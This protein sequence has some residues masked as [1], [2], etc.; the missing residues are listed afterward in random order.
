MS[1]LGVVCVP[2]GVT[3]S[4]SPPEEVCALTEKVASGLL[5]IWIGAVAGVLVPWVRPNMS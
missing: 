3:E 4:Q 5:E 1:T 2:E